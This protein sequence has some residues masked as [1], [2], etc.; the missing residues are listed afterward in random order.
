VIQIIGNEIT[1][2]KESIGESVFFLLLD[3]EE[4]TSDKLPVRFG[5]YS[6]GRL[7]EEISSTFLGPDI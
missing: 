6:N 2:K 1:V 3:K 7:I 4:I 5:I